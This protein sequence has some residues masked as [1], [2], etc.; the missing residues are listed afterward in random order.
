MHKNIEFDKIIR[1][2]AQILLWMFENEVSWN[3]DRKRRKEKVSD[4]RRFHRG[5]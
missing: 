1:M 4:P 3:L 2:R 5:E